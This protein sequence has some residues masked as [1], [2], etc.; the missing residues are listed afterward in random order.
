MSQQKT[1]AV[2][3][4]LALG[5]SMTA[6]AAQHIVFPGGD[7]LGSTY[8]GHPAFAHITGAEIL[9]RIVFLVIY[10]PY[11]WLPAI[12]TMLASIALKQPYLTLG[13]VAFLPWLLLNLLATSP[14]ASTLSNY[15]SFPFTFAL[16][17]PLVGDRLQ[18]PENP[19]TITMKARLMVFSIALIA[20]FAGLRWQHNPGHIDMPRS[21][22][23]A[24]TGQRQRATNSAIQN[25]QLYESAFG[26]LLIDG[27]I[28]ALDENRYQ[29]S[30]L[31]ST[32]QTSKPDSIAFF[33]HGYQLKLVKATATQSG[34]SNLYTFS[35]TD[36]EILTDR[37]LGIIPGLTPA[38]EQPAVGHK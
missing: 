26:H 3:A 36:I 20:S 9:N 17:W 38:R 12:L 21:F 27:S 11:L 8:L 14:I 30:D 16:F 29:L 25:I 22:L 1:L 10:R 4:T 28:A 23:E 32:P 13:Y 5:Y 24:P 15:Y 18:T 31:V 33:A 37:T 19:Q 35:N 6:V 2:F 7:A 34:L